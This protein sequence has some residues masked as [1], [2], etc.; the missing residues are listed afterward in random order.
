MIL[1]NTSR[2]KGTTLTMDHLE[3][4]MKLQLKILSG[5]KQKNNGGREFSLEIFGV[6]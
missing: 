1:V 6:T 3:E 4:A 2:E 5:D